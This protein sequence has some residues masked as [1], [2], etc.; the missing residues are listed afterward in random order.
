MKKNSTAKKD[1]EFRLYYRL[2]KFDWSVL[3]PEFKANSYLFWH[4]YGFIF[5]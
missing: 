5:I 4:L 3:I 2:S 1:A